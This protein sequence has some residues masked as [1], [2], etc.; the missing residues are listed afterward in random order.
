MKT[1]SKKINSETKKKIISYLA[2]TCNSELE[3]EERFGIDV[4][5]VI[6]IILESGYERCAMCD[7]WQH[8]RHLVED[9]DGI[10]YICK[11]C[12]K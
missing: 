6:E 8:K 10:Q 7:Y 1:K 2:D 3:A 4:D 12:G 9:E 5:D 11:D